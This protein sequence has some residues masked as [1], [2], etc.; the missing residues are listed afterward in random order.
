MAVDLQ[1]DSHWR[2][3][4][5]AWT[6]W[7]LAEGYLVTRLGEAIGNAPRGRAPLIGVG[8][9][10]MRS[11]DLH[12]SKAGQSAFWEVKFRTRA[13]IDPLTG[14]RSHW[15]EYAAFRDYLAT[16]EAGGTK[17]WIVLFEA[18]TALA[19]GRWLRA[20]IRELGDAGRP[21]HR[22]GQGGD[23]LAA[24]VWPV[25]AMLPVNGPDV[26]APGPDPLPDPLLAGEGA[27]TPLD[28]TDFAPVERSLRSR[29][30]QRPIARTPPATAPAERAAGVLEQDF[31]TG[32]DVLRQ[33]LGI[34]VM[35]RY[36]VLWVGAETLLWDDV[37][38][39]MHYG[40][41]LF[42]I[43][44]SVPQHSFG[45]V[46]YQAFKHSRML[47]C[48]VVPAAAAT[49]G[50][51][52]VDGQL[53]MNPDPG[54]RRALEAAD[55]SGQMNVGQYR[56][57]HADPDA[58]VLVTAGAGTGK[59][60]AMSERIVF[61][62]AT[63]DCATSTEHPIDLRA[64]DIV[65]M[66]FTREAAREM[67]HRVSGTLLLR[68]RLARRCVLPVV[69]WMLQLATADICTI[70]SYA[71]SLALGGASALGIGPDFAVSRL[72]MEFRD[73]LNQ[74]LSE[75]LSELLGKFKNGLVPAAHEWQDHLR[76][77]WDALEN[78]GV[79]VISYD[80][81]AD[82]ADAVDFGGDFGVGM[83][84]QVSKITWGTIVALSETMSALAVRDQ[85]VSSGQ[86]V[87]MALAALR[88]QEEPPV[89]RP[90]YLFVDEFQDTDSTQ[91]DLIL[92]VGQRL[93]ARLFVVGDAKQGIYRF[94]GAEG[95]AFHELRHRVDRST[96]ASMTEFSLTTN[97]RS[98]PALLNSVEPHFA[99]WGGAGLLTYG[100]SDRLRPVHHGDDTSKPLE[101]ITTPKWQIA[102]GAARLALQWRE[103]E[104]DAGIAVLCRQ[105]W[106]ALTVQKEIRSRG[107]VC[108]LLVGGS[109]FT[110]PAVRELRALLEAVTQPQDLSAALE[111]CE[112]RWAAG[113]LAGE[114][115]PG[116]TVADWGAHVSALVDWK[117]RLLT[118]PTTGSLDRSDLAPLHTRLRALLDLS[119]RTPALAWV[120]ECAQVFVPQ[121]SSLP[122]PD[123]DTERLRYAACFDHLITLMDLQFQDRST[124][125]E[126]LLSWLRLQ[127]ATNRSEDEPMDAVRLRATTTALTVHKAKGLQFDQVL[128]PYSDTAFGPPRK[129]PSRVAV[130][131]KHDELPRLLWEWRV[132]NDLISNVSPAEKHLWVE[133][134]AETAREETRLLYVA[135][136][137]AKHQL[138]VL[139]PES[140]PRHSPGPSSWLDL[141]SLNGS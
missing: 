61:L 69:A 84:S 137:R 26:P 7:L 79:P 66:T 94:R 28:L 78:N 49:P 141:L 17:V 108:E 71:K 21:G 83:Q 126:R 50:Q 105:N 25:S 86:L 118:L 67:R 59:T 31:N 114:V 52:V 24:L 45:D 35:P 136:T 6:N 19:E 73:L 33:S 44:P 101:L 82:L 5:I 76:Q 128:I 116:I 120:I 90:R 106:Q 46:D 99:S 124:T 111:L 109:F 32:L 122:D 139:V 62:L 4:E 55:E 65:L 54:L 9:Q 129:A 89:R 56:I 30:P 70:H 132:K 42:M 102:Q 39:L 34:P 37:L 14:E 121:A 125:L 97:F 11:P 51:W 53:P 43:T 95:N 57:V 74:A 98:G 92:E 80:P 23:E 38:G 75:D 29:R 41:R 103:A 117:T 47:E 3:C 68:R 88:A 77:I 107:G 104:P 48:A 119:K 140:T 18:P 100:S 87:P 2:R 127:I 12:A 93:G 81:N 40:I 72:T 134:D 27:S 135:L 91:M 10:Q 63:S 130:I 110:T 36:S 8:K 22:F 131:R 16:A 58:N 1:E 115:P 112:S 60:E 85:V 113:I 123:D 13:D 133:D 15:M 64:D 138:T 20:E 96:L